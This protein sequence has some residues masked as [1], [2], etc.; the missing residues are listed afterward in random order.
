MRLVVTPLRMAMLFALF[1]TLSVLLLATLMPPFQNADEDA[2]SARA[3]QIAHFGFVA[4]CKPGAPALVDSGVLLGGYT[5]FAKL[6]FNQAVH[7]TRDLYTPLPWGERVLGCSPNTSLY[8]PSF[9]LPAA[10][11]IRVGQAFGLTVL[12]TME[13]AR[14]AGGLAAVAVA[15][16]AIALS[17][18][19]SPWLFAVLTLPMSL[20]QMAAIGQDGLMIAGAALVAALLLALQNPAPGY[21][22]TKFA[23]LCVALALIGTARPPYA[24]L[25]AL[26]LI[27]PGIPRWGRIVAAA[28][29]LAIVAGW[30]WLCTVS[31]GVD[32]GHLGQGADTG[33]QLH[34]VLVAPWRV[35]II[36]YQTLRRYGGGYLEGFIGRLGWLDVYLSPT[37]IGV[38]WGMLVLAGLATYRGSAGRRHGY[39]AGIVAAT[40]LLVCAGIFAIQF[41]T[42]TPLGS[43]F[44]DGIQGRY[45]LVPALIAGLLIARPIASNSRLAAILSMPVLLFPIAS[46][47]VVLHALLLR[48]YLY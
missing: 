39:A 32:V 46:I 4:H 3:D 35:P 9:Y 19:A 41:L 16:L 31:T 28:L 43:A 17:G 26:V 11:A 7:A 24:P 44:V 18:P 22:A 38:A 34:S 13:L 36:A 14:A 33:R 47:V 8:P 42:W 48:Y 12:P 25:A 30:S 29:V 21:R 6:K 40:L 15:A 1:G 23:V 27:V 45:F 37:Y 20:A 10:V 2:H 5:R